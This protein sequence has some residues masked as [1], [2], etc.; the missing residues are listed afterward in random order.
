[1]SL[2][3]KK[4]ELTISFPL[5]VGHSGKEPRS[6]LREYLCKHRQLAGSFLK[7]TRSSLNLG[8]SGPVSGLKPKDPSKSMTQLL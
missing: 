2:D 6:R 1:M 3:S 8:G 5:M 7:G 4:D